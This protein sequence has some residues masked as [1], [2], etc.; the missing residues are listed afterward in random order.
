MSR[1]ANLSAVII[2]ARSISAGRYQALVG[3]GVLVAA[4]ASRSNPHPEQS[5]GLAVQ[6]P[7]GTSAT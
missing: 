5:A 7:R 1:P 2:V 3:D 6:P 4:P